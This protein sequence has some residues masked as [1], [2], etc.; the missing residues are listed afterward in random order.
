MVISQKAKNIFDRLYIWCV[1]DNFIV[2]YD[3]LV[4]IICWGTMNCA[5]AILLPN[6]SY[7]HDASCPYIIILFTF[8]VTIT[9]YNVR[10]DLQINLKEAK[11]VGFASPVYAGLIRPPLADFIN[12]I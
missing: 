3:F 2:N 4:I 11:A 9:L 1:A 5:L 6:F 7:G 8:W 12:L 10:K